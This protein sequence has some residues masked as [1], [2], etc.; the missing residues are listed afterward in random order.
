MKVHTADT[1]DIKL[2]VSAAKDCITRVTKSSTWSW[3][4]DGSRPF[5]WRWGGD[6]WKESRDGTKI[7][8]KAKLPKYSKTQKV[9]KDKATRMKE[10]EKVQKVRGQRYIVKGKVI[11]ITSFFSVPKGKWDIR[12]VYNGTSCGLHPGL[13]YP[14]LNHI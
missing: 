1:R 3:W 4:D 7:W 6:Y 11:S 12:M 5:F 10:Q 2:S 14:L 13:L 9:S 8:I